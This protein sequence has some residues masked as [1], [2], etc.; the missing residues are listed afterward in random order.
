MTEKQCECTFISLGSSCAIAKQ[1][2]LTG[3]RKESLPL[4]WVKSNNF[5]EVIRLF[6]T[7]FEH[8]S[9]TSKLKFVK[10]SDKHEHDETH[11]DVSVYKHTEY[12]IQFFHDF[13]NEETFESQTEK[14]TEK[15]N[16][17]IERLFKLLRSTEN[18]IVF[19]R[20]EQS[21]KPK[22]KYINRFISII[23]EINPELLFSF[24]IISKY[25]LDR[26]LSEIDCDDCQFHLDTE[27][28]G[29]WT[30]PNVPW[31]KLFSVGDIC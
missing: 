1:L 30:R 21:K 15:Y 5:N 25:E 28:F 18:R 8:F 10:E 23:R 17:R 29:D 16:R 19:V 24:I 14:F 12:N 9:D 20:E 27:P 11:G 2:E 22:L 26:D 31:A 3:Y 7:E 4:D 13:S 6:E